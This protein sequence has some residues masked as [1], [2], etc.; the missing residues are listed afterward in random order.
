VIGFTATAAFDRSA[1]RVDVFGCGEESL[2]RWLRAYAGQTQ[3]RDAA[4]TFVTADPD[5]NVAGYYTLLAAQVEHEQ[6][7]ASVRRG[8]SRHFPI[9]VA[10]IA[11]LAVASSH[12]GT[13]LGRSLLLD[14]LQRILKASDELAV[15][16]VT[17]EALDNRAASFYR[18]FGFEP[19]ELAPNTLMV[20][21][22]TVRNAL[23]P[24]SRSR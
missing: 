5:G 24:R 19:T 12:Q 13:G 14:A 2:D 3:R 6:A 4:R 17:V 7:T 20:P 9:P 8:L 16:A 15:R 22:H 18:H 11:R 23:T 10:L 21:L 1:H